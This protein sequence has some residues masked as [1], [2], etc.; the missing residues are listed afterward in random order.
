MVG[1]LIIAGILTLL[2]AKVNQ[3]YGLLYVQGIDKA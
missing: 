2:H 1:L 3:A